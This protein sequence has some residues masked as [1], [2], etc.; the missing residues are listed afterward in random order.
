VL[1]LLADDQLKRT[2][3]RARYASEFNLK[4]LI[5]TFRAAKSFGCALVSALLVRQA[6]SQSG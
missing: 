2:R 3:K 4:A 5:H 6:D 1:N